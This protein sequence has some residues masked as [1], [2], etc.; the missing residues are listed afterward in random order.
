MLL[1]RG[2]SWRQEGWPQAVNQAQDLSEQRSWDG[3]L[4]HLESDI[5]CRLGG[6]LRGNPQDFGTGNPG[7]VANLVDPHSADT[8]ISESCPTASSLGF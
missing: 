1:D 8:D 3:D 5:R 2:P 4:C 6:A 7:L